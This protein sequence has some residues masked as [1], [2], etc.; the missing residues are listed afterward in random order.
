M[1][2][3]VCQTVVGGFQE[4]RTT[5]YEICTGNRNLIAIFRVDGRCRKCAQVGGKIESRILNIEVFQVF[6]GWL[7]IIASSS[8]T[9]HVC[10]IFERS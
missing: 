10:A 7:S 2:D 3:E 6:G 4:Y 1:F 8:I 5:R 9:R